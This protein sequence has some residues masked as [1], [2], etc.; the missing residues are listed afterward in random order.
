MRRAVVLVAAV[1]ALA[2]CGSDEGTSAESPATASASEDPSSSESPSESPSP[3]PSK[4]P[5]EEPVAVPAGTPACAAVWVDG[6]RLARDYEGCR[7]GPRFVE[8]DQE[9]CSFGQ[10]LVRYGNHFYAVRGGP[11]NRTGA[12]LAKDRDYRGALASCRA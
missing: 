7:V 3:R 9:S 8:P 2:G 10:R 5:T 11:V 12:P 4:T 1:V 6:T